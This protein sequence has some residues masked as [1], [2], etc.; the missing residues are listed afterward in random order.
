MAGQRDRLVADAFHQAAVAGDDVGVVVDGRRRTAPRAAAPPAPCRPRCRGPGRAGRSSSRS[1]VAWPY[2]G[3]PAVLEPSC[4]KRRI[5]SIV[6]S[7]KPVRCSSAYSSIEPWPADSTKRSRSGQCG[8]AG[9]EFQEA[10]PQHRRD[11]GHAHRH[12]R[13]AGFGLLDRVHRERADRVRHLGV[14]AALLVAERQRGGGRGLGQGGSG[15]HGPAMGPVGRLVGESGGT[16]PQLAART[17]RP[18]GGAST[19]QN[20]MG[21]ALTRRCN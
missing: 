11:V 17:C 7:A 2:S 18:S 3:W 12:A 6:M 4:R 9:I 1:P 10:R 8:S 21:G 20:R 5:S 19:L 13:M 16:R 14:G 15:A